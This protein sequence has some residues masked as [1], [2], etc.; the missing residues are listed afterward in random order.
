MKR[1]LP[2]NVAVPLASDCGGGAKIGGTTT[3]SDG[4]EV[5]S[6]L[7]GE[8]SLKRSR[9][10][11]VILRVSFPDD[12]WNT[13]VKLPIKLYSVIYITAKILKNMKL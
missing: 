3:G 13:Y 1:G 6:L 11:G 4:E 7:A 10:S 5:M 8:S 2:E 9:F 12:D